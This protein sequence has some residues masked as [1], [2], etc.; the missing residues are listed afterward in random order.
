MYSSQEEEESEDPYSRQQSYKKHDEPPPV[1]RRAAPEVFS[2]L[3]R[4][5][6]TRDEKQRL[7]REKSRESED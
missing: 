5:S 4:L 6:Q 2:R 1:K 3:W 7:Q